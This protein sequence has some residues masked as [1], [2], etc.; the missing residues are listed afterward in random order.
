MSM[1]NMTTANAT[2]TNIIMSIMNITSMA[3]TMSTNTIITKRAVAVDTNMDIII[4]T[5]KAAVA[6]MNTVTRTNM[7][8]KKNLL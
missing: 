8:K 5:K 4:T 7:V 2:D 1:K 3:T 6:G